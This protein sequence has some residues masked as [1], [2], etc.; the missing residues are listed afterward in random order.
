MESS[1]IGIVFCMIAL[2]LANRQRGSETTSGVN[3]P[4][5]GMTFGLVTLYAGVQEW[6]AALAGL[7]M[8]LAYAPSVG[9]QLGALLG[10]NT[11]D[12]VTDKITNWLVP[13]GLQRKTLLWA[14]VASF[15]RGLWFCIPLAICGLVLATIC[16]PFAYAVSSVYSTRF[17]K[18]WVYHEYVFGGLLALIVLGF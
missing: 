6:Q 3:K 7:L 11:D 2:A 16:V 13:E 18:G 15:T 17:E 14:T 9:E 10:K 4:L 12:F 5:F 1:L 8:W